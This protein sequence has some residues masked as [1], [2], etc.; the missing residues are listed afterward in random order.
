[1]ARDVSI[2]SQWKDEFDKCF[3][4][5][6]EASLHIQ[7]FAV[8]GES[9]CSSKCLWSLA[10]LVGLWVCALW[11]THIYPHIQPNHILI[12]QFNTPTYGYLN[13]IEMT[14]KEADEVFTIHVHCALC[15]HQWMIIKP[16]SVFVVAILTALIFLHI[17]HCRE[18][19]HWFRVPDKSPP[20]VEFQTQKAFFRH[21]KIKWIKSHQ[22][23]QIFK[24]SFIAGPVYMAGVIFTAG[25]LFT[26]SLI[27]AA[28][29]QQ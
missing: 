21:C 5:W 7:G 8:K 29:N 2:L 19:F 24:K 23:C 28:T 14:R 25:G 13:V 12:Y 3:N 9:I 1:M 27:L 6:H 4:F 20:K 22:Q 18:G 26:N 10:C 15:K 17:C 16:G 11:F